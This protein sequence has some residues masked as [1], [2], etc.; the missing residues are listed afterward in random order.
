MKEK[1]SELK[2]EIE[3]T[4]QERDNQVLLLQEDNETT[5][6]KLVELQEE[7]DAV[8]TETDGRN[9]EFE[10]LSQGYEELKTK[11]EK[12]EKELRKLREAQVETVRDFNNEKNKRLK[13]ETEFEEKIMELENS[14]KEVEKF[15]ELLR[16]AEGRFE[17]E[18]KRA[19][20]LE[21]LCTSTKKASELQV[22]EHSK[23]LGESHVKAGKYESEIENGRRILNEK[24]EEITR[25]TEELGKRI[26]TNETALCEIANIES[27]LSGSNAE[28]VS[29]ALKNDTFEDRTSVLVAIACLG[30]RVEVLSSSLTEEKEKFRVMEQDLQAK[31]VS[32]RRCSGCER[33]KN[34][35]TSLAQ[36]LEDAKANHRKEMERMKDSIN[37]EAE[38][39]KNSAEEMKLKL[40]SK[41]IL[42][43]SDISELK[44]K[45]EQ[46]MAQVNEKHKKEVS[47]FMARVI[48][49]RLDSHHHDLKF[50]GLNLFC[51]Q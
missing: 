14:Q 21:E 31:E 48:R 20:E 46:E 37:S 5:R 23:I 36:D 16:E 24:N 12:S 30:K 47:R 4:R 49:Y 6:I 34:E 17:N 42:L 18:S 3:R 32:T 43:Q 2:S 50:N 29:S 22:A 10:E 11:A 28:L 25:L 39:L 26:K 44:A 40:T 38:T 41:V 13:L 33:K 45:Q 9:P 7:L 27:S 51:T 8:H 19:S 1:N 15:R 35:T